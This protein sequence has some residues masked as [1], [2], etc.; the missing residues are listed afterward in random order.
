VGGGWVRAFGG[1]GGGGA[2]GRLY[3]LCQTA[4]SL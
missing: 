3:A 2:A 4:A 1:G